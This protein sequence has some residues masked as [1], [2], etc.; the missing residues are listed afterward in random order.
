MK[1]TL[2]E[3]LRLALLHGKSDRSEDEQKELDALIA[4]AKKAKENV[5]DIAKDFAPDPEDGEGADDGDPEDD[6]DTKTTSEELTNLITKAVEKA[7]PQGSGVDTEKLIKEIKDAAGEKSLKMEDV[8]NALKKHVGGTAIDKD[9]LLKD[10]KDMIPAQGLTEDGLVKALDKFAATIKQSAKMEFDAGFG[11]EFPIEHRNGNLSVGQKQLLNICLANVSDEKKSEV[12]AAGGTVPTSMNDGITDEQLK[13]AKSKGEAA[14]KRARH[15]VIYG[16]KALTTSGTGSGEELVPTDLSSDLQKRMYLESQLAS[17]LLASEIDMPTNPF[18][19]PMTTTRTNFYVGSEAPGSDPTE[20]TPGTAEITLDAKKLI[21]MSQYSYESD[22]DSIIAILPMLTE[23]LAAGAADAFEG[24]VING[25]VSGT[26][27][28]SD[29]NAV[30]GHHAKLFAGLRKL[31]LAGSLTTDLSTGGISAANIV[32]MR[33]QLLRWG[34]RPRDLMLVVGPQGYNDLVAL[35]ETLTFEKV[36]SQAA[37]R[38]LTGEAAS[39]FG[40][41]IVISSQVREDLSATGV[42]DGSVT[43]KGSIL[44]VHRPSW[45]VGSKRGFTVEVDVDKK[46]QINYVIASF[47]RD[48]VP[49]ETPSAALPSVVL[50]YNYDA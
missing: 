23:N 11:D 30:S 19:F 22:E 44:L 5:E 8:E 26:H 31:A 40:I 47:R 1:L 32:T 25:D 14:I 4:K 39:I 12:K 33:K 18:K 17:E 49:K 15:A 50:G 6:E 10:I 2:K 27:Q 20:S 21:G 16:G 7:V 42:Y 3:K 41:R 24:A 46:R 35:D 48:M 43:S 34:I 45:I 38:I 37:A 28:D 13:T 36:G 9:A 29:I